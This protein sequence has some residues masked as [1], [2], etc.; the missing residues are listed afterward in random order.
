MVLRDGAAVKALSSELPMRQPCPLWHFEQVLYA[1]LKVPIFIK[2]R[3]M[4]NRFSLACGLLLVAINA[5]AEAP[6]IV[7]TTNLGTIELEL[8]DQRAPITSTNFVKHVEQGH[9][10]GTIFHRVISNFMIQGGGYDADLERREAGDSIQNE[11]TNGLKNLRGTIAMARTGQ[12]HSA[13]AQ[14][15]INVVDNKFL[16]HTGKTSRGWGYAVFGRV[17]E[18]MDVVD[19][20]K[21]LPIESRGGAFQNMPANAAIIIK[22]VVKPAAEKGN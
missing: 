11:A 12:P 17:V 5:F 21:D 3:P 15:F 8:D 18:G 4:L 6:R 14:F 1:V 19:R 10:N 13:Q 20:I 7:M 2:Q 9:Y 22:A 16:D